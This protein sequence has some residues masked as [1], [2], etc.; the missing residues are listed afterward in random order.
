MQ[1][2]IKEGVESK[3][4]RCQLFCCNSR[5]HFDHMICIFRPAI[6]LPTYWSQVSPLPSVVTARLRG[7]R[8][9]G[10]WDDNNEVAANNNMEVKC[11]SC[12][13]VRRGV[14][15]CVYVHMWKN[16]NGRHVRKGK[17]RESSGGNTFL[18][19]IALGPGVADEAD[20]DPQPWAR[21]CG[22]T[23]RTQQLAGGREENGRGHHTVHFCFIRCNWNRLP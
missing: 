14:F 18:N 13:H 11:Q 3:S 2:Y 23:K 5:R 7:H 15:V 12:R 6:P 21:C 10:R 19:E 16:K 4:L 1:L 17:K 9:S 8:K 22:E 20:E